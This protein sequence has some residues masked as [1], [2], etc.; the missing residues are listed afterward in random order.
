MTSKDNL[1]TESFSIFGS[2][3]DKKLKNAIISNNI[4]YY[5]AG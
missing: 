3:N 4:Y 1:A 5:V 2:E